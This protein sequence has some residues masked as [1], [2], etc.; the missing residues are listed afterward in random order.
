MEI[1][2]SLLR[3]CPHHFDPFLELD[4]RKLL[5]SASLGAPRDMPLMPVALLAQEKT[6][7]GVFIC[8]YAEQTGP[9]RQFYRPECGARVAVRFWELF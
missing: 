9:L 4:R 2:L 1:C 3:F 5:F 8:L 7:R 6:A